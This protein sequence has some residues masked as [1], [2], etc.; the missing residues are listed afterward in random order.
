MENFGPTKDDEDVAPQVSK[1][2]LN[3][4]QNEEIIQLGCTFGET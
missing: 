1:A 4:L 3:H 2:R